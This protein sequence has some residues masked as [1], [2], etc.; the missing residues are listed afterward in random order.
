MPDDIIPLGTITTT[1][2]NK[3][4]E[5]AHLLQHTS[6]IDCVPKGTFAS[7][8]K[9]LQMLQSLISPSAPARLTAALQSSNNGLAT[10]LSLSQRQCLV[11]AEH[12]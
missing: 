9:Q 8:L 11:T 3:V 12:K 1:N 6:W 7:L 10:P 4:T 2:H 5:R